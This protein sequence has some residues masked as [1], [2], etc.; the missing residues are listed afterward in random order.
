MEPMA[1]GDRLFRI[2]RAFALPAE[3]LNTRI[4]AMAVHTLERKQLLAL[5]VVSSATDTA[6]ANH[7]VIRSVEE[8]RQVRFWRFPIAVSHAKQ[9]Q[10]R[11]EPLV[12]LCF[13]P[14]GTW[15]A[16]LSSRKNRL[17]L[18][19]VD[20]LV[21]QHRRTQLELMYQPT[22]NREWMS[23]RPSVMTAQMASYL[24][25][26][27]EAGGLNGSRY[28][29]RVA[30]DDEQ[31]STLEF[32][33]GMGDVS[34]C[35]WWRSMNGTNYL[36]VG[37]TENIISMV[38]VEDNAEECRCELQNAGTIQSID[39]VH[40]KFRKEKRTSMLVRT[41][42]TDGMTKY[43]RVVLE[44]KTLQPM[45]TPAS[46]ETTTN[47]TSNVFIPR[48]MRSAANTYVTKTF[49]EHFI[50]DMDF[51]PQRVKKNT[52]N[53]R[54]C[55]ING[56]L[57]RESSLALYDPASH[58]V[59][60]FSNFQWNLKGQYRVPDVFHR[61]TNDEPKEQEGEHDVELSYCSSDLMLLQGT[62]PSGET[63][64][65]WVSL[66]SRQGA[67]DRTDEAHVVHYLSL[68]DNERVER[69]L[70]TTARDSTRTT[71]AEV[72]YL[73]QTAHNVYECRPQWSRLALFRALRNQAITLRDALSI[74]YALGID[75][76]SLCEV[77]ADTLCA[78]VASDSAVM[79]DASLTQWIHDLFDVSR[80]VP[81]KAV[82][83]L[84]AL[85][86]GMPQ[87]IA[88]AQRV[89]SQQP[90]EDQA[91]LLDADE[92][93]RVALQVVKL[94][95]QFQT[96]HG[97]G[98]EATDVPTLRPRDVTTQTQLE[99]QEAWL[100]SFLETN[101]EFET[102]AMIELC[103]AHHHVEKAVFVAVQ[104]NAVRFV[105]GRIVALGL[106]ALVSQSLITSLLEAGHAN[107]L[108][109]ADHRV[110]LRTLPTTTQVE[111]LL[112][113]P[114]AL[115]LHRDWLTRQLPELPTK[116][117][118]K[119]AAQ[120][121]PRQTETEA[122][123]SALESVSDVASSEAMRVTK[124]EHVELF[125][126]ILLH[127]NSSSANDTSIPIEYTQPQL[128]ALL[129]EMAYSYRP[130]ILLTRCVDYA[131]WHAAATIH[132]AHGELV[133]AVECRLHAQHPPR[134]HRRRPRRGVTSHSGV[135]VASS[136][137]SSSF[138]GRRRR[139]SSKE[140]LI[141]EDQE[142]DID[143][144]EDVIEVIEEGEDD[145]DDSMDE[146]NE[147]DAEK[148]RV[149]REDLIQLIKTW[150]VASQPHNIT[151]HTRAAILARLLVKWFEYG[152]RH[153][154]LEVY[155]IDTKVFTHVAAPLARIFFHEIVETVG[156]RDA[157]RT[158]WP[159]PSSSG[160]EAA[161]AAPV[162]GANA[163]DERDKQWLS[164]CHQLPF[165]GQFLFR[166][167]MWFLTSSSTDT[168]TTRMLDVVKDNI[169]KNDLTRRV[170]RL[171]PH[172]AQ[173]IG[174]SDPLETHVKAF[175]CHHVFP[176]RVFDEDVVPEFE[177]RLNT[178]PVPLFATKQLL[179]AEF[180]KPR[181]E[182][183]CPV[184]TFN[185]L[186]AL[187]FHDLSNQPP[188]SPP[189]KTARPRDADNIFY[190]LHRRSLA[191]STSRQSHFAAHR[192]TARHEPW[193]W[194]GAP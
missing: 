165:S 133:D 29:S 75:M 115:L 191:P 96:Q 32:A 25:A 65:T 1:S 63:V 27:N 93:P 143:E 41:L 110:L 164:R 2:Q 12:D 103:L 35:R 100:L 128:E 174:K 55:A 13:S 18:V 187:V 49:P 59:S 17:H 88:F 101:H 99:E 167:C 107:E 76:A 149:L 64:S 105:L 56:V 138:T 109:A 68:H 154:E 80:V 155:L 158:V 161:P 118:L 181:I 52:P 28:R 163:F 125:L 137:S 136:A 114:T 48:S 33:I 151:E 177:K 95:F 9:Q 145:D 31:M 44:K 37:G 8:D 90:S 166:V 146:E 144:L 26:T 72:I 11:S 168:S 4:A 23:V 77:V 180:K 121:D 186:S 162:L 24:R 113:H 122:S 84:T 51:R 67:D 139:N 190:F 120:S 73:L 19:P 87:A 86:D 160:S 89:L 153:T 106:T 178:L 42:A 91:M 147:E 45:P 185:K 157:A 10:R 189:K 6:D 132:E 129:R 69:V 20:K 16:C 188:G 46:T 104:R 184:C 70:Q 60:I 83:S 85:Q 40:E 182:A 150:V 140:S 34:C 134:S 21:T 7:L 81:S 131:N 192:P 38:N 36:L 112:A 47:Q 102:H 14:E 117:C 176:K 183:P 98:L 92:R 193:E 97:F 82:A 179:L 66:P 152:L 175:T 57:S 108:L 62:S 30:G 78:D 58:R 22:H 173:A 15:L 194:T 170:V 39:L 126:T 3:A 53:V 156:G 141:H 54:L 79:A 142:V 171:A 94:I 130:P 135:S 111:I 159:K 148:R 50:E 116:L 123:E 43:Y 127:L 5:A 169:D 172:S 61:E 124:E 119:L 71:D 74:G